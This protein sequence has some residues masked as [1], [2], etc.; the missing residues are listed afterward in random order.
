MPSTIAIMRA[1]PSDSSARSEIGPIRKS[2]PST[3]PTG[4]GS[5]GSG[6]ARSCRGNPAD[7]RPAR[8]RAGRPSPRARPQRRVQT[9]TTI[10]PFGRP[11]AA[12]ERDVAR[13]DQPVGRQQLREVSQSAPLP[14]GYQAPPRKREQRGRAAHRGADRVGRSAGARARMPR[15]AKG[16][17]PISISPVIESQS[18]APR[19]ARRAWCPRRT[20]STIARAPSRRPSA[21]FARK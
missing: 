21:T 16:I 10:Q 12:A 5:R 18:I 13:L 2:R 6:R 1:V 15:A 20:S 11:C 14:I 3:T 17:S 8:Y 7:L 19:G 4:C 9:A